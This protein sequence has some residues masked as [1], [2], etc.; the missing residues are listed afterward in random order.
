MEAK[1]LA[2]RKKLPHRKI[3]LCKQADLDDMNLQVKAFYDSFTS[4]YTPDTDINTLWSSFKKFCSGAIDSCVP[5]KMFSLRFHQPWINNTT[6][7]LS[8]RKK[9]AYRRAKKSGKLEDV[10][11][12]KQNQKDTQYQSKKAYIYCTLT[13]FYYLHTYLLLLLLQ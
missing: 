9:R 12:Y 7:R 5:S 6:K 13:Y 3:Y 8:R 1:V 4:E 2:P 11:R 10:T